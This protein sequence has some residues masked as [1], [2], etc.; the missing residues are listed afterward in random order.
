MLTRRTL[1]STV[2]HPFPHFSLRITKREPSYKCTSLSYLKIEKLF[3]LSL[4]SAAW[5]A[6]T[7]YFFWSLT[8][9]PRIKEREFVWLICAQKCLLCEFWVLSTLILFSMRCWRWAGLT[10][11]STKMVLP[12]ACYA[13]LSYYCGVITSNIFHSSEVV[14]TGTEMYP[15][16]RMMCGLDPRT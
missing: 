7:H 2:G 10:V 16:E 5:P 8:S 11:Q 15:T 1:S 12:H 14:P 9:V 4:R 13:D 3:K 6:T